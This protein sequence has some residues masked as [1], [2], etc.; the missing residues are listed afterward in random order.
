MNIKVSE[1]NNVINNIIEKNKI[2]FNSI[3]Y[4]FDERTRNKNFIKLI[5][6]LHGIYYKNNTIIH[7]KFIF[8]TDVNGKYIKGNNFLYLYDMNCVYKKVE[9]SNK[10][11]IENKINDI[12]KNNK[13]GDDIKTISEF[14]TAPS[15]FI[16]MYLKKYN[17]L[18]YS[19]INIT[20]EPKFKIIS[21]DKTKYDFKV[22]LNNSYYIDI[23]LT[24]TDKGVY[25][26]YFKYNDYIYSVT[27]YNLNNFMKVVG[28]N[29][30]NIINK[31]IIKI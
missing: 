15:T 29:I 12:L 7:T 2:T 24:K 3:D 5:I 31:K 17:I 28:Y 9:F 16:N 19:I 23:T 13:F 30:A 10:K 21:C 6:S 14:L 1:I 4:K 11:D 8:K 27:I 25:T 26:I 20:Y 18:D 22:N